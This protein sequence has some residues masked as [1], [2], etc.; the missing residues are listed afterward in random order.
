MRLK[1]ENVQGCATPP[2]ISE[3]SAVF[4]N[5]THAHMLCRLNFLI[6]KRRKTL[7]WS[8]SYSSLSEW[9]KTIKTLD[10]H[11]LR[12]NHLYFAFFT[13]ILILKIFDCFSMSHIS[14]LISIF[15]IGLMIICKTSK[16]L[17]TS[18]E[19]ILFQTWW[20]YFSASAQAMFSVPAFSKM[21][22]FTAGL[23]FWEDEDGFQRWWWWNGEGCHWCSYMNGSLLMSQNQIDDLLE[24]MKIVILQIVAVVSSYRALF[25]WKSLW[26]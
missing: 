2:P 26:S 12:L 5:S 9:W 4:V 13:H 20:I 18:I 24:R 25:W 6:L 7:S 22:G 11:S 10:H 14:N 1:H 16:R 19:L 3:G 17:F 21:C 15:M 23:T 8:S